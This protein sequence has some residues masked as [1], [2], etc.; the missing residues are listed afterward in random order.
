[1]A[2]IKA[3][4]K[5][6]G[7]FIMKT[8]LKGST[9]LHNLIV[10]LSAILLMNVLV[11]LKSA[12]ELYDNTIRLHILAASDSKED[13][14][15]KLEV[16]DEIIKYAK[17]ILRDASSPEK[18]Y[19]ILEKALPVLKER[20]EKILEEKNNTDDVRV[21]LTKEYYPIRHYDGFSLPSGEYTS[22]RIMLGEAEGQNWWCMVYPPL[23]L[24]AA[25]KYSAEL[26]RA[27]ISENTAAMILTEEKDK[28]KFKFFAVEWFNKIFCR[29]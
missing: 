21:T 2:K 19:S 27:G 22:L 12:E 25:C 7:V 5:H 20:A 13:Q 8:D 10:L 1:M 15:T 9:R 28:V 11:P 16:R 18:A 14:K 17:A 4:T 29:K 3:S 23:C 6:K 26:E 24:T